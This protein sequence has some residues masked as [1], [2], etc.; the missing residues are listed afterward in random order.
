MEL[1]S[2]HLANGHTFYFSLQGWSPVVFNG[3]RQWGEEESTIAGIL[4]SMVQQL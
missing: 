3:Q 2:R 4:V 1:F